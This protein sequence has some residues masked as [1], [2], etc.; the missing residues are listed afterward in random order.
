MRPSKN[1]ELEFFSNMHTIKEELTAIPGAISSLDSSSTTPTNIPFCS[2]AVLFNPQSD[3]IV[4]VFRS[5][6][7]AEIGHEYKD[8][9]QGRP[10]T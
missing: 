1:V 7:G 10:R 4:L 6:L 8:V 9:R 3:H 2:S 5:A